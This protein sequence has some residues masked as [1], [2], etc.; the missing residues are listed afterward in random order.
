MKLVFTVDVEEW[1][2]SA[3]V[4]P[5]W[6][7][8]QKNHSSLKWINNILDFLD[9]VDV[10]G[11]FFVLGEVAE[12]KRQLVMEIH[13]RGHEIA[14]HGWD[15]KLICN[16]N[17][18]DLSDDF[19]KSTN[20]L[21]DIIGEKVIGYRSPCFSQSKYLEEILINHGYLYTS[22][23]IVSSLH[24]RYSSNRVLFDQIVDFPI[25]VAA[26]SNFYVPATGGGWFRLFPT[27]LQ[28][29]LIK[30]SNEALKIFYIHPIDFD[31]D[32]PKLDFI[33]LISRI[34]QTINNHKSIPKLKGLEFHSQNLATFY[35]RDYQ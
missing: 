2:H 1:Y 28:K 10:Q 33:P 13:H 21:E 32:L 20:V 23:G 8:Q 3:N 12:Q 15:H 29:Y 24:D 9:E 26:L 31:C 7:G 35:K 11:T 27:P 17:Y 16:L 22:N 18:S 34:R 25:P 4:A 14:S 6:R 19:T 5:Y 30:N